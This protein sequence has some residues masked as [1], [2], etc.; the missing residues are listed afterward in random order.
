VDLP[1]RLRARLT[2]C[3]EKQ[4]P[5]FAVLEDG[6]PMITPIH[7]MIDCAGVLDSE[8]SRHTGNATTVELIWQY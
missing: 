3:L 6:L 4:F 5:V 1:L 8:L 2:Q 7:D